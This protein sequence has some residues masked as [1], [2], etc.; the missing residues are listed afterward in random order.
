MGLWSVESL[1]LH[2]DWQGQSQFK[3]RGS[4]LAELSPERLVFLYC[5]FCCLTEAHLVQQDNLLTKTLL[6]QMLIFF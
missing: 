6:M 2:A 3:P 4:L 5:S 1:T